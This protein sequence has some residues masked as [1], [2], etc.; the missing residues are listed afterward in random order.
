MWPSPYGS[1]ASVGVVGDDAAELAEDAAFLDAVVLGDVGRG[2]ADGAVLDD[3]ERQPFLFGLGAESGAGEDEDGAV[4]GDGGL[5]L[6]DAVF[7]KPGVLILEEVFKL[8][9]ELGI[10]ELAGAIPPHLPMQSLG[11]LGQ[12][13]LDQLMTHGRVSFAPARSAR[14]SVSC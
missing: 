6:G 14:P 4:D 5:G 11:E 7:G 9:G 8:L 13:D 3:F 10:A 2:G 12:N 1:A